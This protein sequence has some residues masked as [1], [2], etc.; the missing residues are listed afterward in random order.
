MLAAYEAMAFARATGAALG[1]LNGVSIYCPLFVAQRPFGDDLADVDAIVDSA[2]YDS[3]DF[4]Q[5]TGG[6]RCTSSQGR[7]FTSSRIL[8]QRERQRP[9]HSEDTSVIGEP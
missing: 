2:V 7:R 5:A 1:R 8:T 6:R 3:L 4:V 9:H